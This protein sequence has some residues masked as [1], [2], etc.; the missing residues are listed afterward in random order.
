MEAG[1][2]VMAVFEMG[3]AKET[4]LTPSR[5]L[6]YAQQRLLVK[7]KA[8]AAHPALTAWLVPTA[9]RRLERVQP[10]L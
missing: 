10:G 2:T 3:T 5:N 1:L 7:V 9:Q 4:P 6:N 8:A